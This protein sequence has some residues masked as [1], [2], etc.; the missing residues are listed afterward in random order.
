MLLPPLLND[1]LVQS[2][3]LC[4]THDYSLLYA[5]LHDEL[6]DIDLLRLSDLMGVVHGLQIGLW[7]PKRQ[8]RSVSELTGEVR[9]TYQLLS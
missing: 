9:G 1:Q 6:E 7:V 3:L 5:V 2:Q 8:I 4:R